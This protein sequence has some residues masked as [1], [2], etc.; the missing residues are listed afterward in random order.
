MP[1]IANIFFIFFSC[2]PFYYYLEAACRLSSTAS[3]GAVCNVCVKIISALIVRYFLLSRHPY[4][5]K[6][7]GAFSFEIR[8]PAVRMGS[9]AFRPRLATGLALT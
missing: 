3:Q 6:K 8:N 1:M 7:P 5:T 9:V 4:G 2:S